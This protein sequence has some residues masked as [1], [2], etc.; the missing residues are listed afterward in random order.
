MSIELEEY[1]DTFAKNNIAGNELLTLDGA[2]MK[3]S[4]YYT[5]KSIML[6]SSKSPLA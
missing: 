3:V 6:C 4:V 5:Y 1:S 2:R